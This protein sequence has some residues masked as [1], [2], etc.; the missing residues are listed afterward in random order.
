M[1]NILLLL[2][3][4]RYSCELCCYKDDIQDHEKRKKERN[5]FSTSLIMTGSLPTSIQS[6][7][8]LFLFSACPGMNTCSPLNTMNWLSFHANKSL[9]IISNQL[10]LVGK[11]KK[12]FLSSPHDRVPNSIDPIPVTFVFGSVPVQ[13]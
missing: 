8:L 5:A 12:F 10:R 9:L 3:K 4:V 2:T 7:L 11:R 13:E 6:L 1:Y